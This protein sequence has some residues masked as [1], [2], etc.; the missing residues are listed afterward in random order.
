[1]D[2]LTILQQQVNLFFYIWTFIIGIMTVKM[3]SSGLL[4]KLYIFWMLLLYNRFPKL[5]RI[6]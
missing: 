6:T 5:W 3:P 1:M 4:P 2:K